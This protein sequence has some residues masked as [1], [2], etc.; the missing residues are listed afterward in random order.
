M[1]EFL[2]GGPPPAAT[3][4]AEDLRRIDELQRIN[5]GV[6]EEHMR[7]KGTMVR[8]GEPLA[9]HYRYAGDGYPGAPQVMETA[10]V[11]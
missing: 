4:P 1:Q 5:F 9:P 10:A 6:H 11:D 8:E 3:C 7:Y 2:D